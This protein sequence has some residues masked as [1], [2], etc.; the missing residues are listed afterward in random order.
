MDTMK[1]RLRPTRSEV[2]DIAEGVSDCLDGMILSQ[3][4][5]TGRFPNETVENMSQICY[6]TEK[7]LNYI[8]IYQTQQ[9]Q[10]KMRIA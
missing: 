7:T 8:R 10:L 6:E 5:A 3:E 1:T 4:T 9:G 2:C